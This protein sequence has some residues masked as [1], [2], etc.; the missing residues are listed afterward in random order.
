MFFGVTIGLPG[1]VLAEMAGDQA[2]IDVVAAADAVADHQ[3]DVLAFVEVGRRSAPDATESGSAA[4]R[5]QGDRDRTIVG[6]THGNPPCR[7]ILDA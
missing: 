7:R 1:N 3:V 5:M 4:P 6:E 2:G